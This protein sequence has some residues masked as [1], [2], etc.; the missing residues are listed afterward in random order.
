MNDLSLYNLHRP[1]MQTGDLL[2]YETEGVISSLIHLWS[3]ANHAG[4]VLAPKEYEGEENRRWTLEA[5]GTGVRVAYLS[6]ILEKVQG[7]VYWHPL[8][9]EYYHL[10]S[11]IGAWALC[12]SGV[13]KYDFW[14]LLKYPFKW[15]SADLSK[16]IC[17]ELVFLAWKSQG[18]VTGDKIPSPSALEKLGV[19]LPP[20]LIVESPPLE[21]A[22][23]VAEVMP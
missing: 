10:R 7:R 18:I 12:H 17:S 23:H 11:E 3:K 9:P 6:N 1:Q 22:C 2:T 21:P 14:S 4:L 15:V 20:V 16:L 19:T 8:K 5:V 13:T